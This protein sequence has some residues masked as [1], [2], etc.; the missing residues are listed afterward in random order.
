MSPE[1][2]NTMVLASHCSE[3]LE[4]SMVKT[5]KL[6]C[7]NSMEKYSLFNHFA[8]YIYVHMIAG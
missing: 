3:G 2:P 7:A 8:S 4:T 6:T 1:L 5:L